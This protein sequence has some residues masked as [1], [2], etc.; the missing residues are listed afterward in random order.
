MELR[1][2]RYFLVLAEELHFSRAAQR[3]S[4]SQPPLSVAI[5]QLEEELGA[6][7]FERTSKEVR[8]TAA[9]KHLRVQAQDIMEQAQRVRQDMRAIADGVQG[10]IRLGFVGSAIYRGLP[11]A[12]ESF[13][14][15]HPLVRIDMLELNSAEQIASLQQERLD[16]GLLHAT[17][18]APGLQSHTLVSEPFMACLPAGHAL[19]GQRTLQVRQLAGERMVL[20]S[21]QVSPDYHQQIWQ[22]CQSEG[23]TP[24][25][26]YEVRHWLSVL[27]M[28]S[29]GQGVSLVPSC[30]Q[31]VGFP[32]LAFVPIQGRHPQS[33]MQAMWHPG[34]VQPLVE[35]L[36]AHLRDSVGRLGQQP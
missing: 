9:G 11:E 16:L 34:H 35:S 14:A 4:I 32:G 26:H 13:R 2:L 3:L 27:S 30:L 12:L 33:Q 31:R 5:R 28:V 15:R 24:D 23:F 25:L 18:P 22:I 17:R 20:F 10:R 36:L 1:Q 7:L 21:R 6:Q 19:A 8:L 29:L